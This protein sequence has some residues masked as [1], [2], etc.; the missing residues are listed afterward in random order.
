MNKPL[1]QNRD[2]WLAVG[3][4]IIVLILGYI[5]IMMPLLAIADEYQQ[6]IDD[7]EFKIARFDRIAIQKDD[8]LKR[9]EDIKKRQ[10]KN[11]NIIPKKAESLASADLQQLV[12]S[13]V[14]SAGGVLTST[15]V[16]PGREQDDFQRI[17]IK[18]RMTVD[19]ELLRTV[20]H[21]I[22]SA[23]PML[24]IEHLNIR[25]IKGRR[26]RKTRKIEVSDQ[27]N[28]SFEFVGYMRT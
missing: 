20:L 3:I 19:V 22:E 27:L 28:V 14:T 25:G 15:Q 24:F 10:L 6:D 16:L 23:K 12:K 9:V 17:A 11:N 1:I 5:F 2:R 21:E 26:N 13:T 8:V 4:L 7:L 18:V